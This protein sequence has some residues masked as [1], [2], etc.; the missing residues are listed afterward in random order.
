MKRSFLLSAAAC[1]ALTTGV[2]AGGPVCWNGGIHC[3]VPE[4]YCP[5]C[6]GPCEQGRHHNS[7][8]QC[9][10]AHELVCQLCDPCCCTRITAAKKLGHRWNGDFCCN[11]EVLPALVHALLCDTCWE[12]RRAAAWS[13]A[14]QK[15]RVPQ[16][17][18]AL[19]LAARLDPH[20]LVRDA[21]SD[22]LDVLLVC[23][24][25]CF[26]DLFAAADEL[27]KNLR[28]R[29][30]PTTGDCIEL[31]NGLCAG[32]VEAAPAAPAV[33]KIERQPRPK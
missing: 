13:I 14:Y 8:R 21:S 10:R 24:R 19:Y 12:V 29:Y 15:A 31:V 7:A 33:E 18:L 17:V 23:R 11:E 3:Q 6:C 5:D 16:G 26:K 20:Y 30:R 27:A 25:D 4:P 32:V 22:A 2:Y 28:G 9:A 1:L